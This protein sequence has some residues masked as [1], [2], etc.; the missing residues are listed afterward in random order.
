MD[1]SFIQHLMDFPICAGAGSVCFGVNCL[2]SCG[3][4]RRGASPQLLVSA[5]SHALLGGVGWRVICK[6]CMAG[7]GLR[8]C[9]GRCW[10]QCWRLR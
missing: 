1:G 4:L 9:S 10:R 8:R 2:R 3:R 5:M 7:R 6:S